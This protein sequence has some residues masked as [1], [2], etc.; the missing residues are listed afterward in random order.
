MQPGTY[1]LTPFERRHSIMVCGALL[2]KGFHQALP[3]ESGAG[4]LVR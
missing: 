1:A 4:R 3:R 2:T